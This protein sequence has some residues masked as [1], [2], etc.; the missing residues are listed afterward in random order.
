MRSSYLLDA[1][2]TQEIGDTLQG[3]FAARLLVRNAKCAQTP[4]AM[5]CKFGRHDSRRLMLMMHVMSM[6][7]DI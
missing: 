4:Y 6:I 7:A 2:S 1:F 3:Y 5:L